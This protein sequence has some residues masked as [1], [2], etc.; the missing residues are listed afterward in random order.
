VFWFIQV[1]INELRTRI[2]YPKLLLLIL[3]YALVYFLLAGE[4]AI[5][6][7][8][9]L[10]ST[11]FFGLFLAGFLYSFAFTAVPATAILLSLAGGQDILLA[12]I[13]ASFGALV[14]DL[15]IFNYI[16]I[17]FSDEVQKLSKEKA[18]RQVRKK[19]P[20][21]ILD[22]VLGLIALLLIASPLPTELGVAMLSSTKTI[23]IKKFF[24]I[25]YPLHTI[26]IF[27]ILLIGNIF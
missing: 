17:G 15:I 5:P 7:Q 21:A 13:T 26:A 3:S 27:T 25:V 2:K 8:G 14:S 4:V 12:G 19:I 20:S 23:S 6:L 22:H 24:F 10:I 11:G 18:V 9:A 16:R 1:K